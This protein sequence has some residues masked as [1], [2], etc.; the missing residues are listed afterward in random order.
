MKPYSVNFHEQDQS[1]ILGTN[2]N[3]SKTSVRGQKYK[4][5]MSH[6]EQS[7]TSIE[8]RGEAIYICLPLASCFLLSPCSKVFWLF[9]RLHTLLGI[10]F[11]LSNFH[12]DGSF[13]SW[14]LAPKPHLRI[15][16]SLINR[17]RN[18]IVQHPS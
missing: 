17:R 8:R 18:L 12:D 14:A 9:E 6:C 2:L 11:S 10:S 4:T 5:K 13:L 1:M 7:C 15:L 3:F 16:L